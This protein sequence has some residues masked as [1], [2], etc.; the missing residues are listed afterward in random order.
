[1]T[2]KVFLNLGKQPVTNSYLKNLDNLDKEYF[3]DLKVTYNEG[4]NLV[5]LKNFIKPSMMFNSKYAHRASSSKTMQLHF[6]ELSNECKKKIKD[7]K[8]LEIGSNDGVFIK[9]FSKKYTVAVEPC[10]NLAKLTED[11]GYTTYPVFWNQ[12]ISNK[13]LTKHGKRNLI[14][15]ANTMS[16]IEDL[17]EV[18]SSIKKL[19]DKDGIFI[20]EDPYILSVLQ[21][22]SYD[23]FY[24]EHAHLFSS[25]SVTNL[26]KKFELRVFDA[27]VLNVHGG[28]IR[29]YICHKNGKHKK[30]KSVIKILNHELKNKINKFQTYKT[31]AN[32]VKRSKDKLLKILKNIKKTK[33]LIVG[34]GATYKSSTIYNYCNINSTLI[35]Y[36]VDTTKNK[37]N[38]FTP[39]SHIKILPPSK[40][41]NSEI[42]YIFLSAWNFKKEIINKEI[43]FLKQGGCFITHVPYPRTITLKDVKK[44]IS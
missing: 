36:I 11:M 43:N 21:N 2:K 41:L 15:S 10:S 34:Y 29:F 16:H 23:Q 44:E 1:M 40:G 6:K 35:D 19:L 8:C 37:Q 20:F 28:S 18:F 5:S 38:K 26:I 31:F 32:K 3:Y 14:F 7:I 17:D 27:K 22:N 24:D 4:N 13:I 25:L 30:T 39:G 33:K 9:N 42:K 12:K